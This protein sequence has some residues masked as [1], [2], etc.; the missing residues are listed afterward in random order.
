MWPRG[1]AAEL[2]GA[3]DGVRSP[4]FISPLERKPCHITVN[5]DTLSFH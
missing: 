4:R 2:I 3:H 1:R 5:L